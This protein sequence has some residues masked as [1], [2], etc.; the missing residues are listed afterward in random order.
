MIGAVYPHR[1]GVPFPRNADPYR[2][3]QVSRN[4]IDDLLTERHRRFTPLQRLLQRAAHQESWSDQLRA[5]LP[6]PLRG[7]CRVVDVRGPTVVVAC[8]SAAAATRLR[9]MS[10]ELLTQL[11]QLGDFRDAHELRVRVAAG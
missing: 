1:P 5:L 3:P 10:D 9:F 8:R 2:A 6:E 11:R 4:K 7:D